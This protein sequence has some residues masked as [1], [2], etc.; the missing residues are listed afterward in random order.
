MCMANMNPGCPN[1]WGKKMRGKMP[2]LKCKGGNVGPK[3]FGLKLRR[4]QEDNG[5]HPRGPKPSVRRRV[6]QSAGGVRMVASSRTGPVGGGGYEVGNEKKV[7][8]PETRGKKPNCGKIVD[9]G[10]VMA[11]GRL[12]GHSPRFED[13]FRSDGTKG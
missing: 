2:N 8:G 11:R 12:V 13:V 10:S 5:G 6:A 7:R 1:M 4:V 3:G 9:Q